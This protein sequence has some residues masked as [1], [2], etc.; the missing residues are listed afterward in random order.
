MSS[1]LTPED[2]SRVIEMA[3]EDRT[4]FEAIEACFG[5]PEKEVIR[6]MRRELKAGSFRLWR[7]RVSGRNTKHARLRAEGVLRAYCPTQ[8]KHR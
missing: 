8:Y 7:K 6:L 3:W 2:V 1:T 4:P 5:L